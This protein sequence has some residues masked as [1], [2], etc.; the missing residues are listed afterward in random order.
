MIWKLYQFHTHFHFENIKYT[1]F[2]L[3][4]VADKTQIVYV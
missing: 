1:F 4:Y 3:G 2:A